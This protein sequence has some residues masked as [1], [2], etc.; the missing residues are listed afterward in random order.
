MYSTIDWDRLEQ[1]RVEGRIES[2]LNIQAEALDVLV[3]R[4]SSKDEIDII[5]TPFSYRVFTNGELVEWSDNKALPAYSLLRQQASIYFLDHS[6]GKYIVQKR[7][8]EEKGES[9]EFFSILRLEEN[10]QLLNNFLKDIIN[11]DVF[12]EI[13]EQIVPNTNFPITYKG[14]ILFGITPS[15]E[16]KVALLAL[17]IWILLL[18]VPIAIA[19]AL[20][21]WKNHLMAKRNFPLFVGA[22][23]A[24]RLILYGANFPS[25]WLKIPLFDEG[26]YSSSIF[27]STLGDRLISYGFLV[28]I[29][30]LINN[31]MKNLSAIKAYWKRIGSLSIAIL[32]IYLNID[33]FHL[34]CRDMMEHSQIKFDITESISFDFTRVMAFFIILLAAVFYFIINHILVK[35]ISLAGA[36]GGLYL[37]FHILS[38]VIFI[39]IQP[40][41][42]LLFLLQFVW[43]WVI[44]FVDFSL[45]FTLIKKATLEYVLSIAALLALAFSFTVYQFFESS[46][47]KSKKQFADKLVLDIDVLGEYYLD[48]IIADFRNNEF[49]KEKI[50]GGRDARK[51]VREKIQNQFVS[52]YFD[53]YELKIFLFDRDGVQLDTEGD[54]YDDFLRKY[55]IKEFKTDYDAIYLVDDLENSALK[56]YVCFLPILDTG[57]IAIELN[58]K[59]NVFTSVFPE[60]LV[61]RKYQQERSS[62]FDYTLFQDSMVLYGQGKFGHV[63][64]LTDA[65]LQNEK[66]YREGI[67]IEGRHFFGMNTEDGRTIVVVSLS[68]SN[69]NWVINFSFVFLLFILLISFG[70]LFYRLALNYK[71]LTLANKIQLYL[72]LGFLIPLFITGF[73]LLNTLN[74][75]YRDE[76]TRSYLKKS[77]RISENL[78]DETIQFTTN[79]STLNAFTNHV[80]DVSRFA[81][82][83]LNIYNSEGLLITTSQ[84]S[85]FGIGLLSDHINP[86]ALKALTTTN[87]N[88]LLDESIG[89]LDFKTTYTSI[90]GHS[91]RQLCGIVALPFFDSKNHLKRQQ[92]EVFADLLMIFAFIFFFAL[93]SGNYILN[94]LI[95]SLTLVSDH[96]KQT[97]LGND[98]QPIDY[99]SDD[100]IGVL[101]K[102]YNQMLI[103]LERNKE[104]L[105]RTQKESAWKEIARQ[106]AHEIKNPLT[107]MRL[108][109]QQLQRDFTDERQIKLLDSMITQ[110]DTLS[111]IADSFSEFAKMPAPENTDFDVVNV[112]GESVRLHRSSGVAIESNLSSEPIIIWADPKIL[113]R[114]MNNLLLNA[115]QSVKDGHVELRVDVN[116]NDNKV[117]IRC[118]D[119]GA[120]IPDDIKE[121]IF[122]TYFSTKN[123]GSGIGL[124]IAK[125][126]IEN[127][128]GNIWFESKVGKGTTFYISLPVYEA[129]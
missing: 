22:L 48:G 84:P 124:A 89:L 44:Y 9:T 30:A 125:K 107:P 91:N 110:I 70:G 120:G 88:I 45:Q 127:A 13:P 17:S 118:K 57:F 87:Q 59:R 62:T 109:I 126:G 51:H 100:E 98:N 105:A 28:L 67:S 41:L 35:W 78:V 66:L 76:I 108:K 115:I 32:L 10:F 43:Y 29:A 77:L 15:G 55:A 103:K 27:S 82:A 12:T 31:Q 92:K 50:Q 113:G 99:K 114:I 18:S 52:S 68:Y 80:V 58:R 40:D 117:E 61:E 2:I 102:E 16:A 49:I 101:V 46:E 71:R 86:I 1:R 73:T 56:K 6:S 69:R 64:Y 33:F 21:R 47:L 94:Y 60:L 7:T 112:I 11:P 63:N 129:V 23:V 75:S 25:R 96:I 20:A 3:T 54:S 119:N 116:L 36:S 123:T 83:D 39:Q 14:Q 106:V 8:V 37:L 72:A 85:I 38:L 34:V 122:T 95:G 104:V 111:D 81:Q 128:G 24:I 121:K 26:I 79:A 5:S 74:E 4:F 65:D 93:I 42:F 53:K 90:Y 19:Y 97:T